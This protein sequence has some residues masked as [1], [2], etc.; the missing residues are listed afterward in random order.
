MRKSKE[1]RRI[2]LDYAAGENNP[3]AIYKEGREA[4]A[5]LES[6]RARI[7][8]VLSVA[9]DE[10]IFTPWGTEANA[11]ASLLRGRFHAITTQI[12]HKSVLDAFKVLEERG[13]SVTYLAPSSDGFVGVKQVEEALSP[14]TKLVSVMYANNEMGTIEPIKEIARM[15]RAQA[16][17]IYFHSDCVQAPGLL[18]VNMQSLGV[19]MASFSAP[20]F[21][22]PAGAAFLYVRRSTELLH[23]GLRDACPV[24]LVEQMA[25][26]LE[27]VERNREKEVVRFTKLRDYFITKLRT[28]VPGTSV[29]GSLKNRLANNVNVVLPIDS[30]LAVLELD[31]YGIAASAGAACSNN[32]CGESTPRSLG[33][34]GHVILALGKSKKQANSSVRFSL[35]GSTSKSQLDYVV[36]KLVAII[37]KH[38]NLW[39]TK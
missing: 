4:K 13:V 3:N 19:D 9:T 12:E 34:V 21:G 20:K 38:T 10:I 24:P 14:N 30:E 5:R 15:L 32:D 11:V 27:K 7:A 26:A 1:K 23:S 6:A 31:R 18:P 2:F 35:G 25:D 16:R 33:G 8:K 28:E 22:G 36:K 37:N 29:N 39:Q 17:K